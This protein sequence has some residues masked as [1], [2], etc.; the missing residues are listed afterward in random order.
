MKTA[1]LVVLAAALLAPAVAAAQPAY[2]Q[3]PPPPSYA[4][5]PGPP[6]AASGHHDRAGRLN[7]GFSIGLGQMQ[8][9]DS[10]VGCNGCDGDPIAFQAD[11]HLGWMLSPR[12][13]LLAELQ[14][15]GQTIA[16][17]GFVT[18]TLLQ[19]TATL[20]AQYWVTPQL[21]LKAGIGGAA[22]QVQ[23][24]DGFEASHSDSLEGSALTGAIGY[25]ILSARNFAIDLQLRVT[26]ARYEDAVV[27]LDGSTSD[28]EVGTTNLGVGFTWF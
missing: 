11:A 6:P 14:G 21:W 28:M 17:D 20:G 12:L 23:R 10:D 22:L 1:S 24:D 7:L 3:P 25:E 2:S 18:D 16:D 5:P 15:V 19:S 13:S 26:G 27:E 8:I 4:P 9:D